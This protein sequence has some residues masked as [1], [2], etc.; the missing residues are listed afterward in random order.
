VIARGVALIGLAGRGGVRPRPWIELLLI[1]VGYWA[2]SKVQDAVPSHAATAFAHARAVLRV[3]GDMRIAFEQNVNQAVDRVG[4]LTVAMN[5]FYSSMWLV[6]T[7]GALIWLYVRKPEHYRPAR[8]TLFVTTMLALIGFAVF[9]LAP[10]RLMPGFI[11]TLAA[12]HTWGSLYSSHVAT[13][14]N[15]Y[16]ATPSM[17]MAWSLWAGIIFFRYTAHP[18]ARG[19]G[20]AYPVA[21]LAVIVSTANH[22]LLDAV[23]G[24]IALACGFLIQRH[25]AARPSTLVGHS[26]KP[27]APVPETIG[28]QAA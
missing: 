28:T 16:A 7:F 22:Y 19:L 6:A 8:R 12:H 25:A 18:V 2:Y 5:Y 10:P 24:A 11:D 21:T 26:D 23:C 3:E 1:G 4:W 27:G 17:H 9:P 15:P 14:A 13:M 20:L